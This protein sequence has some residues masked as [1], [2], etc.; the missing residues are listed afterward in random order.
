[1]AGTKLGFSTMIDDDGSSGPKTVSSEDSELSGS[2]LKRLPTG[3]VGPTTEGSSCG[4]PLPGVAPDTCVV[5][6]L[7]SL[8][9]VVFEVTVVL[10]DDWTKLMKERAH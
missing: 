7:V 1:M 6:V 4:V 5:V 3:A 8:T 10:Y 2:V 9:V